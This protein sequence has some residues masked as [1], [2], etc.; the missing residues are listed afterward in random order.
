MAAAAAAQDE[1]P[2]SDV[3]SGSCPQFTF[4]DDLQPRPD[5]RVQV[6]ADLAQLAQDGISELSGTV[7]LRYRD[8]LF[9]AESVRFEQDT[10]E[11]RIDAL[12]LY[13]DARL[14]VRSES[15]RFSLDDE[16]GSFFGAD[17]TLIPRNA[18]GQASRIDLA[19]DGTARLQDVRYTTCAA[20]SRAWQ[21][22]AGELRLDRDEGLGTARHTRLLFGGV[23]I[24]YMPWFQFPIDDRRRTGLLFPTFGESDRTGFDLRWPLYLNLGPNYDATLTPRLMSDRGTML[25][26]HFRYLLPQH[27]GETNYEVLPQDKRTHETR[28]LFEWTH[29][30]RINDRLALDLAYAETSDPSY[31]EDFSGNLDSSAIPF[32]EQRAGLIYRN[33]AAYR[34]ELGLIDYQPI[35]NPQAQITEPHQRLPQIRFDAQTQNS[36]FN[37][38]AGLRGEYTNFVLAGAVEGQRL[39][40]QPYLRFLHDEHAWF[41]GSQA[42]LRTTAYA[43]RNTGPGVDDSPVRTLPSFSVDGGLRFERFTGG[44]MLQTL[45]PR[46]QYLYT[47]YRNQDELPVFDSGEPDFDFV[48]LF[49]RNRFSGVDRIA[50]ANHLAAEVTTRWIDPT[51]GIVKLSAS[52][53][54]VFRFE[55]PEVALPGT[56]APADG[57]TDFITSLDYRLS[58]RWQGAFAAQWSPDRNQFNRTS[59]ILRYRKDGRRVDLAYRYRRGFVEQAD[60]ALLSPVAER[61]KL[62]GRWRYSLAAHQSLESLLGV[63][64]ETCCWSARTSWRRYIAATDGRYSNGIYLQLEFKGLGRIGTGFAALLPYD[65]L[66]SGN[67]G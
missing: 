47:P 25:G 21:L 34:V 60:V 19:A 30:G 46:V 59:S 38:R 66:D 17:F 23:P 65:E 56:P 27:R 3:L 48:Q 62:A 1:R 43:L 2:L 29:R 35:N 26:T 63:E 13:R 37:T 33:P 57:G 8:K 15:A 7:E 45:E 58:E 4:A 50:D 12:S 55:A 64:Y 54:K 53:G 18:R 16:R 22:E 41:L 40:L 61:W 28:S 6:T 9:S 10:R 24:L 32:L 52:V 36:L 44:D 5:N 39:D 20:G 49:A 11:V 14:V 51:D 67:G 31:F 42:E